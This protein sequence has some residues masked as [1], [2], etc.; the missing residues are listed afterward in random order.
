[1]EALEELPPNAHGTTMRDF[2]NVLFAVMNRWVA[3][4][5]AC[6]VG[7]VGPIAQTITADIGGT[8]TDSRAAF[9]TRAKLTAINIDTNIATSTTGNESGIYSIRFL[10]IGRFEIVFG[11]PGFR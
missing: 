5:L 8:I 2:H 10:Q 3:V 4:W 1:M 9:V 7:A 6:A 11:S